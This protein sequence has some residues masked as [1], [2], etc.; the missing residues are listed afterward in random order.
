MKKKTIK[1]TNIDKQT[2]LH[3]VKGSFL[4]VDC[5]WFS[6]NQVRSSRYESRRI[7]KAASRRI[8]SGQ[9]DMS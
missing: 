4:W 1:Q 2:K 5:V 8:G 6:S 7:I 3:L 9:F